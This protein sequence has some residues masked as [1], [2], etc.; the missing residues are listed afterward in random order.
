M[1]TGPLEL[2]THAARL[3]WGEGE[4]TFEPLDSSK[5]R[6]TVA[7]LGEKAGHSCA[8][9]RDNEHRAAQLVIIGAPV[10]GHQRSRGRQAA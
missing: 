4:R 10:A 1:H 5:A 3:P 7:S 8:S 6:T 2:T 9:Q